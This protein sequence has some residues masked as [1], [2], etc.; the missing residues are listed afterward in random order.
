MARKFTVYNFVKIISLNFK[1]M[2][3]FFL[4]YI[5]F[6][7]IYLVVWYHMWHHDL[8]HGSRFKHSTNK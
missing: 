5:I 7:L 8:L 1:K 2:L 3:H 4:I 6:D